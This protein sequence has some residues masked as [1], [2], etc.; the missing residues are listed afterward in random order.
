MSNPADRFKAG[1]IIR[2]ASGVSALFRYDLKQ[3]AGRL[4]GSHVLGGV[5]GATDVNF[6]K[7]RLASPEDLEF[8]RQKRPEWFSIEAAPKAEVAPPIDELTRPPRRR[9]VF[10]AKL[11]ADDWKTL[12]HDLMHL[13]T[14]ISRHGCLSRSS[15]SGGYS[16]GHIIVTSEDGS[17]DHDSWAIE[18]NRYLESLPNADSA[19][20]TP[21]ARSEHEGRGEDLTLQGAAALTPSAEPSGPTSYQ[22][23]EGGNV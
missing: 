19:G 7:L 8:C 14:E 15:V 12:Q 21:A 17:I 6:F 23:P 2:Y 16:S 5:H 11:Q 4:Y 10:I 18:L 1:D 13:A 20:P 22:R 9:V 3:T